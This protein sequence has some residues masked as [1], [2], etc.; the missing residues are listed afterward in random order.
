MF[1]VQNLTKLITF[2]QNPKPVSCCRSLA[3]D[4]TRN[5]RLH[6]E[7]YQNGASV[8]TAVVLDEAFL[9]V[10]GLPSLIYDVHDFRRGGYNTGGTHS[11]SSFFSLSQNA[12]PM[13][14]A[15]LGCKNPCDREPSRA[16][17][18][19]AQGKHD[20]DYEIQS[21][22]YYICTRITLTSRHW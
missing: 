12:K 17:F 18:V 20:C 5:S 2:L 16:Q 8:A 1:S 6:D 14:C 21:W 22:L 9:D 15:L 3:F 19:D 11:H 10:D 4:S 13:P 7:S